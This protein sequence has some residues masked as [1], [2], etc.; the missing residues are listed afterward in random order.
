MRTNTE[1]RLTC[2]AA[3]L[4]LTASAGAEEKRGKA[5]LEWNPVPYASSYVV[6]IRNADE[7]I[8]IEDTTRNVRY[9]LVLVPGTYSR[10]VGVKNVFGKLTAWSDWQPLKLAVTSAPELTPDAPDRIALV[11][12]PG[13]KTAAEK[14]HTRSLAMLM[15]G[16]AQVQRGDD[17]KGIGWM[18]AFL[19]LGGAAA[20]T[21]FR[22]GESAE[23]TRGSMGYRAFN[24]PM[25]F[26]ALRPV[27]QSNPEL[28]LYGLTSWERLQR[29]E[30]RHAKSSTIAAEVSIFAFLLYGLQVFDALP[31]S[32]QSNATASTRIDVHF[33][34][35]FLA[36][37]NVSSA[38]VGIR[39]SF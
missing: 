3:F 13:E 9:D 23:R 30:A 26:L 34:P 8:V 31:H 20:V 35:E 7:A 19:G 22:S 11:E 18:V 36:G 17:G 5:Y 12:M 37:G 39:I 6:Q 10:R 4:L 2:A 1:I 29:G 28:L 32:T 27:F 38:H 33:S 16:L 24:D 14:A 15:P 25:M 21:S